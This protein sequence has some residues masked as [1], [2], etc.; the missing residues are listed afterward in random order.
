MAGE[1]E[2]PSKGEVADALLTQGSVFLHLDPRPEGV[3]VPGWLKGQPQ[4]VLQV[5][6]HM[7]VPIP[8]LRV[9]ERGVFATL[10]FNRQPF[11][12]VVPWE[13]VYAV[14]GDDGRGMVW[15]EDMP[16]EIVAEVER[17]ARRHGLKDVSAGVE[18]EDDAAEA[19]RGVV[20]S[21]SRKV[22][23]R[24]E[25]EASPRGGGNGKKKP[26]GNGRKRS[27][28]NGKKKLPPYLRV[29]K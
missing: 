20:E 7:P 3:Q 22:D 25:R 14:V 1:R 6:L 26:G 29:V 2:I 19:V 24:L 4:V 15:P 21:I 10:S 12:C 9:D 28:G 23:E 17:E 27:G 16:P 13:S 5:G 18:P 8:D 11:P